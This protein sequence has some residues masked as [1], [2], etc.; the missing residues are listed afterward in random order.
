MEVADRPRSGNP[1]VDIPPGRI[2][3]PGRGGLQ[4]GNGLFRR[5][6]RQIAQRTGSS[7]FDRNANCLTVQG[8]YATIAP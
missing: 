7:Y 8:L 4:G 5:L 2:I 3:E 6:R 1:I